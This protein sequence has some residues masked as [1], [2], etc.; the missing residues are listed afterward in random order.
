MV[1]KLVLFLS[2][3]AKGKKKKRN[4]QVDWLDPKFGVWKVLLCGYFLFWKSQTSPILSMNSVDLNIK[5]TI[6]WNILSFCFDNHLHPFPSYLV[7]SKDLFYFT[8][9]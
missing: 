6:F 9:L 5:L 7:G 2:S 3:N 8:F 4:R 1:C